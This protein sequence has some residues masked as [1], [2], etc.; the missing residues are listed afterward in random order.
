[1]Q[2]AAAKLA[3]TKDNTEPPF[4]ITGYRVGARIFRSDRA[5]IYRGVRTSDDLPVI[6]KILQGDTLTADNSAAC[7]HEY[8]ILQHLQSNGV[9]KAYDLRQEPAALVLVIEDAGGVA[10]NKIIETHGATLPLA[11]K[12]K[13]ALKLVAALRDVHAADV[14]HKDINPNNVIVNIDSGEIKL[15]DF[16]MATRLARSQATEATVTNVLGTL[17]YI[18]PEQ[19]GRMNRA[20]DYRSDYYS[21]GATLYE[22]FT[23]QVPFPGTDTLELIHAHIAR[24]PTP[25]HEI[26]PQVPRAVSNIILKLLAKTSED[27]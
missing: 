5:S 14:I 11:D 19:T 26:A 7:R 15:I 10:L 9:V 6:L 24:A 27:R 3:P 1:M 22:L 17:P 4:N 18:A 20:V 23:G 13:L 8:E 25:P 21:L 12:L 2:A 16:G